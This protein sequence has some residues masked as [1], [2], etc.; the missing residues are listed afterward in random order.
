MTFPQHGASNGLEGEELV[1][2]AGKWFMVDVKVASTQ[3]STLGGNG[4]QRASRRRAFELVLSL[5]PQSR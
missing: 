3:F 5:R 1:D 2:M 4:R